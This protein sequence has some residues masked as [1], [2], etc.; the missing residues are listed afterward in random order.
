MKALFDSVRIDRSLSF[1]KEINYRRD[2]FQ[3]KTLLLVKSPIQTLNVNMLR[4]GSTNSII[5][6]T[7]FSIDFNI[8]IIGIT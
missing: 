4:F 5:L 6:L 7:H 8:V 3:T 1:V 2:T